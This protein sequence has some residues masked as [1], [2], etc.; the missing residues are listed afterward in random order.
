MEDRLTMSRYFED[1]NV[2]FMTGAYTQCWQSWRYDNVTPA[3]NKLYYVVDGEFYLKINDAEYQAQAGQMFLLPY[4]S[5]QTYYHFSSHL[6]TKYWVHFTAPCKDRDLLELISLPHFINV[7]DPQIVTN[8]FTEMLELNKSPHLGARLQQKA[9]LF[10]LLAYYIEHSNL[11]DAKDMFKDEK[12]A[13]LMLY[14]EEHLPDTL[15]INELCGIM[16]FHPNYFIRYFKEATGLSPMEYISNLRIEH[17]KR[18]LQTEEMAIQDIAKAVGFKSSYYF[19]RIF[20]RKTGFTPTDYRLVSSSK[21][22]YPDQ[23]TDSSE[24][25]KA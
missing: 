24:P 1:A 16:H 2:E 19:A 25:R 5:T 18:M 10:Q 21:P 7:E 20:K 3:Y 6:A 8:R 4:N 15:T 11:P 9:M 17:A 13:G 23:E 22:I 12:L 14:I